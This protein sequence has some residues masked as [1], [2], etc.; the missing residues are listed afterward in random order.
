M[1]AARAQ[2]NGKFS[3]EIVPVTVKGRKS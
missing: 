3:N 1:K 2:K